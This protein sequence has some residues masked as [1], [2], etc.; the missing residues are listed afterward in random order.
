MNYSEAHIAIQLLW[1]SFSNV[2][3]EHRLAGPYVKMSTWPRLSLAGS[4][5]VAVFP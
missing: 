1:N 4:D 5:A 2:L 3:E